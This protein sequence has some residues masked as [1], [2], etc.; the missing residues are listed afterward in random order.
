[1]KSNCSTP[2][3][4]TA[5]WAAGALSAV[6]LTFGM[7]GAHAQQA[8]PNAPIR[9]VVG[10]AA[11]GTTDILARSLGEQLGKI[12]GQTIIVDNKPGAASNIGAAFVAQAKPDGYTL[13]MA[14]VASHGINPALYRGKL[15]FDPIKDFAPVSLVASIPLMLVVNPSLPVKSI[16]DLI[17]YAKK[18]PGK[19]NY[20]SSGN[21]SP[22]HLA[23]AVFNDAT[24][25]K[26]EHIPFKG[27]NPANSSVLAG[28]TQMTFATVPGA[29]PHV[30]AGKL[31]ALGVTTKQRSSELP[32]VPTIAE[33]AGLPTYDI[34]TWNA[35]LAPKGTPEAIVAKLNAAIGQAM[36]SP[37]LRKRFEKEG[38]MPQTSTPQELNKFIV[39]EVERW[40]KVVDKTPMSTN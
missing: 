3:V 38:A 23:A 11:G 6:A 26:I 27:G 34:S 8:Y 4:K 2:F 10:Y 14:T 15:P 9:L 25:V 32:N 13:Y 28:E 30:V 29:L 24:Q 37:E 31:V 35:V 7:T 17:E 20:A 18:N 21:G 16:K 33:A 1:M 12:L 36:K 5:K 39:A 40:G 22:G 19:L